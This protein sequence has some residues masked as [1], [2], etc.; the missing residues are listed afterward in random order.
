MS[1]ETK[2]GATTNKV[3][4]GF[5]DGED[6]DTPAFAKNA[7]GTVV[8]KYL[9]LPGD[10][11]VTL[12]PERESASHTTYSLPNLHGDVFATVNADGALI[13][14]HVSGPFGEVVANSNQPINTTEGATYAYVGQHQKTE[15]SFLTLSPTQMGARVYLADTGRFLSLDPVEGGVDNSYVYPTQPVNEY[16]L[17]GMAKNKGR[18]PS[19]TNKYS[20]L[21]RDEQIARTNKAMGLKYNKKHYNSG[22]KKLQRTDKFNK[23]RNVQKRGNYGK[24]KGVKGGGVFL[25]P[26]P[27]R[28]FDSFNDY[29]R[30]GSSGVRFAKIK[31]Y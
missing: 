12:R 31:R 26:W 3:L 21:S 8:E 15:E 9:T 6:T 11:L 4:Y 17:T 5:T 22:Q 19:S 28:L 1:R 24:V 25:V 30:G 27:S 23:I 13:N 29:L 18:Q 7:A 2:D 14:R 16:D 20:Y 10:V